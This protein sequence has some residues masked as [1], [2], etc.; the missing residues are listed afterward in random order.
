MVLEGQYLERATLIARRPAEGD[1]PGLT[2]EGLYHRGARA[3]GVVICAPHPRLGGSMDS[4]VVAELAWA[5]TR[6]GHGSLRFN[7]QGVG[8][9]MGAVSAPPAIERP[10][11]PL[12][13]SALGAEVGDA[14]AA[15]RHLSETL[16][17]GRVA[18][19]GYSFG[20]GVALRLA[21]E[22]RAL[23]ALVLI[24]PPTR[25]LDFAALAGFDRPLLVIAGQDDTFV[26][27]ARL[28]DLVQAAHG[29]FELVAGADHTFTRGLTDVGRL[30]ATWL[31]AKTGAP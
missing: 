13:L 8:A 17:H 1:D 27:R 22:D 20:A 12:E 19:A 14:A 4:P 30:V 23:Q 6:L 3:P 11:A 29:R 7:Y 18:L 10:G 21:L 24:A 15:V 25:M 5:V 2:L 16:H 26:E 31:G 28:S 9:S